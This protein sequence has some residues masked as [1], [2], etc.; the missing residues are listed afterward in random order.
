MRILIRCCLYISLIL[1]AL[2]ARG[3][4]DIAGIRVAGSYPLARESLV[5]NGA[6]VRSKFFVKVYV[7]ALYLGTSTSSAE[8]IL[9]DRGPKSMQMVMLYKEIEADNFK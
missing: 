7:G 2:P 3:D 5:L 6:G 8:Q 1:T 4:V 9:A